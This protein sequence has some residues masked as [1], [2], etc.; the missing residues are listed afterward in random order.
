VPLLPIDAIKAA[1]TKPEGPKPPEHPCACCGRR[2]R[3]I[4][5]FCSRSRR[6][7]KRA[8]GQVKRQVRL[9]GA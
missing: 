6:S 9:E 7:S 8:A 2:M 4:E 5:T 3:I 1:T